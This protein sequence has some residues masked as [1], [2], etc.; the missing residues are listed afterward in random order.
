ME[1]ANAGALAPEG[2]AEALIERVWLEVGREGSGLEPLGDLPR[3]FLIIGILSKHVNRRTSCLMVE[4]IH[5]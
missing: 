2:P 5:T 1:G 3:N 4:V